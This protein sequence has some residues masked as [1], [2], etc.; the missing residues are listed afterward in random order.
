MCL[1]I[2]ILVCVSGA[3]WLKVM[4]PMVVGL[5]VSVVWTDS[6]RVYKALSACWAPEATVSN[7]LIV[8]LVCTV[9]SGYDLV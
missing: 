6:V 9:V 8:A 1:L 4:M 5:V 3:V 2:M 7:L